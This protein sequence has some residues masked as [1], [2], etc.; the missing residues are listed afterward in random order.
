MAKLGKLVP[1]RVAVLG[2]GPIG[3]EAAIYAIAAGFT[4]DLYEQGQIGEFVNRW[5]FVRLFTPFGMNT[6][7][8]GK[9]SLLRE[10]PTRRFPADTELISGREYRDA[11]LVPLAESS[12]LKP[13]VHPQTTVVSVGRSGVRKGEAVAEGLKALP[14]FRLLLRES[15]GAEKFAS[16]D[17]VLDCTGTYARPNWVGDGG[18]PAAGEIASRQHTHYWIDDVRG[19]KQA[20]YAGKS[21]AVIGSGYSAATS[22]CELATLAEDHQSTW[23][24]WL[25]HG[26]RSPLPRIP[27]DSLRERDRLAARANHLALRCDGNLEFHPLTLIDELICHGADKGFRIAAR[28]AGVAKTWE[29]ERVIAN[30]GYRPDVSLTSELRVGEQRGSFLTDEPGY[31]VLGAKSHGRDSNWLIRDGH[32]QIRQAIGHALGHPRLDLYSNAS[33]A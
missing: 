15:G 20:N 33:A 7:S 30:V 28:V 5:G 10:Q 3:L 23:I 12:L 14:P 17:V 24:V 18:I 1:N 31:Y 22:V 2:G 25:T 29:V 6:T 27:G 19:A 21:I 13:F 11:Y 26:G 9:R 8:L 32:A 4:V 16:A